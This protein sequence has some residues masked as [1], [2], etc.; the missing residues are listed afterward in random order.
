MTFP[1][2]SPQNKFLLNKLSTRKLCDEQKITDY[3]I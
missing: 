3:K 2:N 1:I